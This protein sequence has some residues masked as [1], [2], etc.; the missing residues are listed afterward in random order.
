[1]KIAI[2][3]DTHLGVR[4]GNNVF[5]KEL[6]KFLYEQFIPFCLQNQIKHIIHAGDFYDDRRSILVKTLNKSKKFLNV[7]KEHDIQMFVIPGNHDIYFKNTLTPNSLEPLFEDYSN[8]HF[9][10][11]PTEVTFDGVDFLFIP[12]MCSENEENCIH[13]I[14]NTAAR[15]L[16]CHTD[17]KGSQQVPGIY[18]THGWESE[19]FQHFDKVF[20]G[21]I[22]TR[23]YF[24]NI[25]NLG[26]Q[27]Q[28][29]WSDF[30][31]QK[32]FH[33]F[34]TSDLST[35]FMENPSILYE[36]FYY[37]NDMVEGLEPLKWIDKNIDRIRNRYI[38]FVVT[39]KQ[40]AYIYDKFVNRISDIHT[41]E[42]SYIENYESTYDI[43]DTNSDILEALQSKSTVHILKEYI[44]EYDTQL[45]KDILFQLA[46][47]LY[48]EA[49]NKDVTKE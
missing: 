40:N 44:D 22:H 42:V 5:E 39:N 29:N 10:T 4:N 25:V 27:Y 3:N 43:D 41:H 47:Q 48:N 30:G 14:R 46:T 7:L 28:F 24:N 26:T 8:V 32:G 37:D 49:I 23:S 21:H 6:D 13:H 35:H 19:V 36:K 15:F 18:L 20:N 17:I 33:I 9:M 34:D 12:W 45:N 16:V 38:K 11:E 2:I 31:Q 1:M